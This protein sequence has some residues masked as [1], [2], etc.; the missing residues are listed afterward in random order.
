MN[1]TE[2]SAAVDQALNVMTLD[3]IVPRIWRHDHTVWKTDP[4]EITEP[5]RLGWL[6]VIESMLEKASDLN[7]FAAEVA[8]EGYETAVV[9]GMGGSSLAPEVFQRTF[10][11]APDMLALEVLDTT[12]PSTIIDLRQR[13]NLEKT[14]FIVSSKSGT[15][16]E[17]LSQFSYFWEQI[18]D[19]LH[20]VAVTDSGT[21]LEKLG[22][23]RGFR[24]V[25]VNPADIGGRYSALSFFGLVPASLVGVDLQVLLENS[26]TVVEACRRDS[27]LNQNPGALLG[28]FLGQAAGA[29]RDKLT[30]IL[31]EEVSSLGDWVEQ[32]IA[33]STGKEGKGV[34]PI[35]GEALGPPEVYGPDR[36]F[37]ALGDHPGL[38]AL[39]KLGHPVLRLPF[40]NRMQLGGEFFRWEFATAVAAH[41]LQ[42]NP[43][44]QPDV[45]AAKDATARI[46]AE[47][48]Q[49]ADGEP[50]SID[51]V[52]ATLQPGD[53]L[54]LLAYLPRKMETEAPL[55][56]LRL[57]IRQRYGVATS[58]G[59]GPRYLHSTGQLHKGGPATG[60]FIQLTEDV[61]EDLPIPGQPHS[62]DQ[63]RQAQALGDFQ[64]L[65]ARG[66]RVA[67][68]NLGGDRVAGIQR[69][70][71][72]IS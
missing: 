13:L 50:A 11:A 17:T 2:L 18:P 46:L 33:E 43:F 63:L 32:L 54:G 67:Q 7:R 10:G 47:G 51:E 40:E 72:S 37:V 19:G 70:L 24:R 55:E 9:L 42:I 68:V 57:K 4:T 52:L 25:F 36:A 21:P 41:F 65:T 3:Q 27:P 31:P 15:T 22:H 45:Q 49:A 5:N 71:E 23:D 30:L 59:F 16:Q 69:L 58:L 1:T 34:V 20:F 53:Y 60:A 44:D 35:A 64:S 62:F 29:G 39:E 8:A 28:A 48:P 38:D 12:D 6:T 14:L 61:A 66:R 26:M 56:L